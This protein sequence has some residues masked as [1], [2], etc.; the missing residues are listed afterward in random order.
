MDFYNSQE[1]ATL[2][3]K[4]KEHVLSQNGLFVLWRVKSTGNELSE[5][6]VEDEEK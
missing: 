5:N 6:S 4:Q 2:E 3:S 1:Y